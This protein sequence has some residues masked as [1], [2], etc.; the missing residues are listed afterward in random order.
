MYRDE[1]NP[2]DSSSSGSGIPFILSALQKLSDAVKDKEPK[3]A[4]QNVNAQ[5]KRNY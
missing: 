3:T 4:K 5:K 1:A 2:L